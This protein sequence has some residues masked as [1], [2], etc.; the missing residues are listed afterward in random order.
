MNRHTNPAGET[1][2]IIHQWCTEPASN[3]ASKN[4]TPDFPWNTKGYQRRRYINLNSFTEGSG[5]CLWRSDYSILGPQSDWNIWTLKGNLN[6]DWLTVYSRTKKTNSWDFPPTYIEFHW[7]CYC[8]SSLWITNQK[9]TNSFFSTALERRIVF[10]KGFSLNLFKE[11]SFR[12][13]LW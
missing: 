6:C 2:L 1:L 3:W 10:R 13:L 4:E 11:S 5:K 8:I 12:M 7:H 9:I